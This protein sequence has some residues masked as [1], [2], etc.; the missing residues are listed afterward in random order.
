M[1]WNVASPQDA[2]P[3]VSILLKFGSEDT[4]SRTLT[5]ST[6]WLKVEGPKTPDAWA[7]G[8]VPSDAPTPTKE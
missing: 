1:S 6:F 3:A 4:T 8:V 2:E 7:I 5:M